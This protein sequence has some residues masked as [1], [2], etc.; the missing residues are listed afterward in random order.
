MEQPLWQTIKSS[1]LILA[2]DNHMN[3]SSPCYLIHHKVSRCCCRYINNV[4][5]LLACR[6]HAHPHHWNSSEEVCRLYDH[7]TSGKFSVVCCIHDN[8]MVRRLKFFCP[9]PRAYTLIS[10]GRIF[11]SDA[12]LKPN[13]F[14]A[15]TRTL[16]AWL[17][18]EHHCSPCSITGNSQP[19]Q[20][21][22]CGLSCAYWCKLLFYQHM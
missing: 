17:W 22:F 18:G 7:G 14:V 4:M 19:V 8:F 6:D 20:W 3:E 13:C 21:Q 16:W 9:D 10:S 1:Y 15:P 12:D 2:G 11:T 5:W